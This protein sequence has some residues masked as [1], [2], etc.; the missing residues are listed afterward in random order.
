MRILFFVDAA[1]ACH[2]DAKGHTG[3]V[4]CVGNPS[5]ERTPLNLIFSR[6]T[7]QKLV[8]RS[9][10]ESELVAV[11]E[12]YPKV[13]WL[14]NLLDEMMD[15]N[16][17]APILY[18]DNLSAIVSA[19]SG[20]KRFSPMAHVNVR[21]FAIRQELE[22]ENIEMPHLPTEQMLSDSLTKCSCQRDRILN[23]RDIYM[24]CTKEQAEER[25]KAL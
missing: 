17:G 2:E 14:K 23:Q 10:T 4:G 24:N 8:S 11:H 25:F 5:K 16:M 22:N 13:N 9:S 7:K 19:S 12:V 1:Y 6:S 3:A 21:F 20:V 18:Q 15:Q